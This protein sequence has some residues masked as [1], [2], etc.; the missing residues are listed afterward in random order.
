VALGRG[1]LLLTRLSPCVHRVTGLG[2][3]D[4][5]QSAAAGGAAARV[6]ARAADAAAS[7]TAREMCLV[8]IS[9]PFTRSTSNRRLQLSWKKSRDRFCFACL[10]RQPSPVTAT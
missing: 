6:D 1:V 4:E 2:P 9:K 10:C 3:L 8:R 7:I 5:T